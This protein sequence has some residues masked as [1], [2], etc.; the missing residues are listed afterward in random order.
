MSPEEL[1]ELLERRGWSQAEAGKR[2]GVSQQAVSYWLKGQRK[3]PET[4]VLLIGY[5]ERYDRP[6]KSKEK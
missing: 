5:I 2:L 3:I 1:A 4:V 6:R